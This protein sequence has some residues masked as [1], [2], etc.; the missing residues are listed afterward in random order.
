MYHIIGRQ[1][2]G[3]TILG[4]YVRENSID[5]QYYGEFFLDRWHITDNGK[6]I[7][8]CYPDFVFFQVERK[9]NFL[10]MLKDEN[11]LMQFKVFPYHLV[12]F[13][14][15]KRL[16]ELLSDLKLLTIKRNPFD[17]FLSATYQNKTKWKIRHRKTKFQDG[18]LSLEPFSVDKNEVASFIKRWKVEEEFLSKLNAFHSFTYE[19]INTQHLQEF[20]KVKIEEYHAPLN[21][22]YRSLIIN[23]NETEKAFNREFTL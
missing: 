14:Y 11:R 21:I 8:N 2:T 6:L 23:L 13:G 18:R 4:E 7:E 1:R 16:Y 3:T 5:K 17:V 12:E 15:E 20:F 10:E 9:F 19:E 22:D